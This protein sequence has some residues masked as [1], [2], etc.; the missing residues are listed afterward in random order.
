MSDD[1]ADEHEMLTNA[2]Q[3]LAGTME[4]HET[5]LSRLERPQKPTEATGSTNGGEAG[6]QSESRDRRVKVPRRGPLRRR[7]RVAGQTADRSTAATGCCSEAWESFAAWVEGLRGQELDDHI[8]A[9][10]D[11]IPLILSELRALRWAWLSCARSTQPSFEW[12]HWHDA[13]GRSLGRI[14]EWKATH[15]RHRGL[16]GGLTN[17]GSH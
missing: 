15:Q 9:D 11:Q 6:E 10:W 5:R 1:M 12:V 2:V 4:H 3:D 7:R 13:L 8:P 17:S 16:G 14:D